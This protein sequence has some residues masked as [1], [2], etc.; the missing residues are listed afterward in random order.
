MPNTEYLHDN[1]VTAKQDLQLRELLSICFTK[2]ED[3][4]FLDRRYFNEIPMHR[5]IIKDD[6]GRIIAHTAVH[7]KEVYI[8]P[9][10]TRSD[11]IHPVTIRFG[12]IAE[13]SVHPDFRGR[14]YVREMLKDVHRFLTA[15]NFPFAIL[16]GDANIYTSSGYFIVTN[17]FQNVTDKDGKEN[18]KQVGGTMVKQLGKTTWTEEEVTLPGPVF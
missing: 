11:T 2:P 1:N 8:N 15:E 4:V 16:L 18:R 6:S 3:S 9:E 17:I 10:T 5:W 7:E 13:V 14:G 12:G